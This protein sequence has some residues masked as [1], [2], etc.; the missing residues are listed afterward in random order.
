MLVSKCNI[1][2]VSSD[3]LMVIAYFMVLHVSSLNLTSNKIIIFFFLGVQ[4][5]NLYIYIYIYKQK[6]QQGAATLGKKP[7]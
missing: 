5:K 6:S 4:P 1:L 7:I 3:R 2:R